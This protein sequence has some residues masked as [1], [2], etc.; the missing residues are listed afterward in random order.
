MGMKRAAGLLALALASACTSASP[1]GPTPDRG[2]VIIEEI[3]CYFFQQIRFEQ[4]SARV[5]AESDFIV[6]SMAEAMKRDAEQFVQV[7]VSG[8]A[9]SDEPDALALSTRRAEAVMAALVARGVEPAR[10]RA[11]G[12]A[13]FCTT[14]ESP[15]EDADRDRRVEFKV[16]RS[17]HGETGVELGCDAAKAALEPAR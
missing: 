4:G 1:G 10:M 13:A 7:E 5:L 8:H 2:A 3:H 14:R 9:S 12:Y 11:R 6:D 15:A 17:K 16:L